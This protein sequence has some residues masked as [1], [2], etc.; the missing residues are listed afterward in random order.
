MPLSPI[1]SL[2]HAESADVGVV[3]EFLFRAAEISPRRS[4][5]YAAIE[6]LDSDVLVVV[7]LTVLPFE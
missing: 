1:R 7:V 6:G 4:P 2:A 3:E 5:R